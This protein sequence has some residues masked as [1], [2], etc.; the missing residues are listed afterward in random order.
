[1]N[2]YIGNITGALGMVLMMSS[3]TGFAQTDTTHQIQNTTPPVTE[4][5]QKGA[6]QIM[7]PD[8]T[9][10]DKIDPSKNKTEP[11]KI[12]NMDPKKNKNIPRRNS[13]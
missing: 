13:L 10:T 7:Q 2:K 11:D 3:V 6:L 12:D 4:P 5:D 8:T 1:M 9:H